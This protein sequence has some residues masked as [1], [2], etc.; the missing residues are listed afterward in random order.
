MKTKGA[1]KVLDRL[2]ELLDREAVLAERTRKI[3]KEGHKL[4]I[5]NPPLAKK[6]LEEIDQIEAERASVQADI[7]ATILNRVEPY[8]ERANPTVDQRLTELEERIKA[9]EQ[10]RGSE[11]RM[12]LVNAKRGTGG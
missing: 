6:V 3:A 1:R 4:A 5:Y 11:P 12:E 8:M 2:Y 9:L 7:R 10:K